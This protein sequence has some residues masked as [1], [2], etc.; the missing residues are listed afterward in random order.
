MSR[1]TEEKDRSLD[2]I[3]EEHQCFRKLL[4]P[5][6]NSTCKLSVSILKFAQ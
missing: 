5:Y 3:P 6:I 1:H 4:V 2:A